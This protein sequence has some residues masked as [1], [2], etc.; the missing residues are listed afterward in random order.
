M[1]RWVASL[2]LAFS[3]VGFLASPA[4]ADV[5]TIDKAHA[6]GDY[7][8]AVASGSV[9]NP[10][11]V[12]VIIRSKPWQGVSA[13]WSMTCS[14]GSGAGSKSGNFG[15]RTPIKHKLRRP[16]ARPDYCSVAVSAQLKDSGYVLVIIRARVP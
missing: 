11:K 4:A 1:R 13:A 8:I 5:V 7:A 9:R 15:G 14:K 12:F 16:Y 10:R 3:L 6:R 2:E